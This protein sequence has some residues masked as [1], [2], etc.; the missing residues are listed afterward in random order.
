[1]E[2]EGSSSTCII[3][4]IIYTLR[5]IPWGASYF[6]IFFSLWEKW[7]TTKGTNLRFNALFRYECAPSFKN[8]PTLCIILHKTVPHYSGKT[9]DSLGQVSWFNRSYIKA[10]MWRAKCPI[11]A[12]RCPFAHVVSSLYN[13]CAPSGAKQR[14]TGIF[15]RFRH[16]YKGPNEGLNA[17]LGHKGAPLPTLC[18]LYIT[19]PRNGQK[20][21]HVGPPDSTAL[22]CAPS[23]QWERFTGTISWFPPSL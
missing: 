15:S 23:G 17:S 20:N 13:Y 11:K 10:L 19:V 6:Y 2:C 9:N 12:W 18:L 1:M 7:G 4:V 22:D 21:K 5:G 8:L 16:R 14:F 3:Y